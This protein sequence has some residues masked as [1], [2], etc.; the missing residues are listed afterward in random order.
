MG[1][2]QT[3]FLGPPIGIKGTAAGCLGIKAGAAW[4]WDSQGRPGLGVDFV[5][6]FYIYLTR[7]G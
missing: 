2:G 5:L 7:L 4:Y 6:F 3:T 1:Q